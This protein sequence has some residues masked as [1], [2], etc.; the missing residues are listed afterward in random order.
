MP[1]AAVKHTTLFL[2]SVLCQ[3]NHLTMKR[4]Y[5]KTASCR[6]KTVDKN[7]LSNTANSNIKDKLL[8][9]TYRPMRASRAGKMAVREERGP[10][11]QTPL[12]WRWSGYWLPPGASPD[13]CRELKR[14]SNTRILMIFCCVHHHYVHDR[15]FTLQHCTIVCLFAGRAVTRQKK[16]KKITSIN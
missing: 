7:A 14:E 8:G 16:T 10:C 12:S 6:A 15:C 2:I 3:W 1:S 11:T 9:E 5:N 4:Q 13:L